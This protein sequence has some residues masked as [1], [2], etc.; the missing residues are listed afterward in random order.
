MNNQP[1]APSGHPEPVTESERVTL[2]VTAHTLLTLAR[3]DTE[4]K[5]YRFVAM[6]VREGRGQRDIVREMRRLLDQLRKMY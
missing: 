2:L 3:L 4:T 5:R 1:T 6:L